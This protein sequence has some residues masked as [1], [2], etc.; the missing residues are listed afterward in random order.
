[1][2]SQYVQNSINDTVEIANYMEKNITLK[3]K[4]VIKKLE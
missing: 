1:M 4:D 2:I 3:Y